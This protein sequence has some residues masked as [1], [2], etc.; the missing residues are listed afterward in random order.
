M[1]EL[2][3]VENQVRGLRQHLVGATIFDFWTDSPKLFWK[4]DIATTKKNV[5]GKKI[6]GVERRGKHII[7]ALN[8]GVVLAHL[9]MTGHFLIEDQSQVPWHQTPRDRFIRIALKLDGKKV[10]YYSD[11]RK[12]GH[13]YYFSQDDAQKYLDARLGPEP[14]AITAKDFRAS[15]QK[16]RGAI[17]PLLL[18]QRVVA[19]LGNI[20]IDES[21]YYAKIHP[22]TSVQSL[23]PQKIAALHTAMQNV[24][25][26]SIA[27]GG[28][29]FKD[30]VD[31]KARKGRFQNEFAVYASAGK[32]CA[33]TSCS[34][35][36][37]KIVV[38]TRG[39]HFCPNCQ[40]RI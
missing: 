15:L 37:Q 1:P 25:M 21:L 38:A 16:Y 40:K 17:K 26:K 29:S 18:G 3:E 39:T 28:S 11:I 36:I 24:L 31:I 2:P 9:G 8:E 6:E 14:L 5:R 7:L 34:G 35:I 10:L 20:Y 27:V 19:G 32:S 13:F 4:K 30:F 22:Q 23:S 33:R 12:F